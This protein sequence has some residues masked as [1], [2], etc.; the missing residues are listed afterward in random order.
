MKPGTEAMTRSLNQALEMQKR[1][2]TQAFGLYE[3]SLNLREQ[4]CQQWRSQLEQ[5]K[6][7]I[8]AQTQQQQERVR[9]STEGVA[10]V[11]WSGLGTQATEARK[12]VEQQW[13]R[14]RAQVATLQ[15]Q[16]IAQVNQQVQRVFH[17]ERQVVD[18]LRNQMIGQLSRVQA[19]FK[20][21]QQTAPK[22]AAPEKASLAPAPKTP[23]AKA[24]PTSTKVEQ[25]APE[26][27][28]PKVETAR[29][30]AS[31]TTAEA[32]RKTTPATKAK[33]VSKTV[34]KPRQAPGRPRLQNRKPK[35][36]TK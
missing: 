4:G 5:W 2:W 1:L 20:P 16:A 3:Q 29:R 15:E 23:E 31:A 21:T 11:L 24:Q 8:T 9:K 30:K 14:T 36:T 32:A 28:T 19:G 26:A 10:E 34:A 17:C 22:S 33:P 7:Q 6:K 35:T 25:A 18:T 13:E 12:L 27:S